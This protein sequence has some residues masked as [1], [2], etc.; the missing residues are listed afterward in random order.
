[1][2]ARAS[3]SILSHVFGAL[4]RAIVRVLLWFL[5]GFVVAG[6]IVEGAVFTATHGQFPVWGIIIAVIGGVLLGYA[7]GLTVLVAE[8]IRFF[9]KTLQDLEKDVRGELTGG[10]RVVEGI[11]ENI[12]K[13][14]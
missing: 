10:T 4:R 9:V 3:G 5:I 13:R 8:V 14:L 6:A 7:A 12:E 2:S 1:M 11:V